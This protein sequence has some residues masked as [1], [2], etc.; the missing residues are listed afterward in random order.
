M[1]P[2]LQQILSALTDMVKTTAAAFCDAAGHVA[3]DA[4]GTGEIEAS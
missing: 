4:V 3:P 2:L 1:N